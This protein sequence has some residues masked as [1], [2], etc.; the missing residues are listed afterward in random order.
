MAD[1]ESVDRQVSNLYDVGQ[2]LVKGAYGIVWKA[3]DKRSKV[4]VAVKKIFDAFQNSTDAQRTYREIIFLQQMQ[5]HPQIIGLK[6]VLKADNDKDIYLVFEY[7]E[8]DLHAAIRANIL[9]EVHKKYIIYQS[10]RALRYMHSGGLV[11]RDMKPANLLLNAECH[12]KVADFGLAR[13][14]VDAKRPDGSVE[15]P[16]MTDYVA[17][18]WYRAPEVLVGSERYGVEVDMWSAGCIFGEMLLGKPVLAGQ[19]TTNQLEKIVEALGHPT[20]ADIESFKSPY[21]STMF[22]NVDNIRVTPNWASST[23]PGASEQAINLMQGLLC[24]NPGERLTA[25]GALQHE[26]CGDFYAHEGKGAE[27]VCS[28]QVHI[29]FDDNDKKKV[30]YYRDALNELADRCQPS[31]GRRRART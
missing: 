16:S 14:V 9:E 23:F 10:F 26:Y 30:S 29:D 8:T 2:K 6:T 15:A 19:S 28:N 18:R 4:V 13:S 31:D 21:A 25:E 3:T 11:H 5:D 27:I 7:M 22:E 12:M 24:L 1:T 17:T 20:Q